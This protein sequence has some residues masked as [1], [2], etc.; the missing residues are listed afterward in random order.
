MSS[1][2]PSHASMYNMS[3][4]FVQTVLVQSNAIG[5]PTRTAVGLNGRVLK[6]KWHNCIVSWQKA[7]SGG[8]TLTYQLK[9]KA[10]ARSILESVAEM[11][12]ILCTLRLGQCN[13][14]LFLGFTSATNTTTVLSEPHL[15]SIKSLAVFNDFKGAVTLKHGV[16]VVKQD[17]YLSM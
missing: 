13:K 16:E 4:P 9:G 7:D 14:E 15:L 10:N 2:Y 3:A 5:K 11:C 1:G 8:G 17:T 12:A 6:V